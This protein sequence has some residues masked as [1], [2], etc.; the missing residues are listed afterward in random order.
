LGKFINSKLLTID[1]NYGY[2]E[3]EEQLH[4]KSA[5]RNM[6]KNI[7]RADVMMTKSKINRYKK[8]QHRRDIVKSF[9][10]LL[11]FA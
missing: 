11:N 9:E 6:T 10:K 4:A 1:K 2:E 7:D 3:F 5:E 8:E